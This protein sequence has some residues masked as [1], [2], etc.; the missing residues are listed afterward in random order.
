MMGI[1]ADLRACLSDSLSSFQPSSVIESGTFVGLGSTTLLASSLQR[2]SPRRCPPLYT[3]EVSFNHWQQA[4]ANL[5]EFRHVRCL[6][7]LSVTREEAR[8][9]VATDEAIRFHER[10][11]DIYIDDVVDPVRFYLNEIDGALTAPLSEPGL[12]V[13]KFYYRENWLPRL[14]KRAH[15]PLVVLDSAGAIGYLEFSLVRRTL[16]TR[17]YLLLLD[18]IDHLKHF[19]SRRDILGDSSFTVLGQSP[20][21]GWL[22]AEHRPV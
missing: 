1:D 16:K 21:Q 6:W 12:F 19:R 20:E 10:E 18:D 15:R 2:C 9:F 14:L 13:R 17:P 4:V 3:I 22:L 11:P 5:R 7:G 8:R